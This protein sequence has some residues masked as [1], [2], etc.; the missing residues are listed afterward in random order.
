[1]SLGMNIIGPLYKRLKCGEGR[2]D[3]VT[4]PLLYDVVLLGLEKISTSA[5]MEMRLSSVE[6]IRREM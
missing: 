1:M 4:F 3:N 5:N 6:A 2:E